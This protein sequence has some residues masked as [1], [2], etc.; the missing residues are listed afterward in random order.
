M[1]GIH[2]LNGNLFL[3]SLVNGRHNRFRRFMRLIVNISRQI[4]KHLRP[5]RTTVTISALRAVNSG[6]TIIRTPPRILV[7]NTIM[8]LQ[9]ARDTIV[10]TLS[11]HRTMARTIR[12]TVVNRRRVTVRIRLSRHHQA[13]R[14]TS[15]IFIFTKHFSNTNR[16]TKGGQRV[17]GPPIEEARQLRSQ[18]R[19]HLIAIT[20]RR[21]RNTNGIFTANRH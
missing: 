11:L 4:M 15:R 12:G 7:L 8:F 1:N 9:L 5:R 19:P 2:N 17:P 18:A 21:A 6:L 13:R 14:H 20:T 3:V 16:I 10:F